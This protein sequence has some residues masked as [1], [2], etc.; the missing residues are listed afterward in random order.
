M[1]TPI[2][3]AAA[4][5]ALLGACATDATQTAA[6]PGGRD[7][8]RND[9]INGWGVIDDHT[10]RV[11]VG[12]NRDYALTSR[13]NVRDLNFD[14]QVAIETR[15]ASQWICTGALNDVRVTGG[16]PI[17]RTYWITEVA[18]IPEAPATAGS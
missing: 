12:A 17:P 13:T 5:L 8:F 1:R 4:A 6:A 15:G 2:L 18:R 9:D 14:V 7:C 11:S 16:G 3:L 10:L